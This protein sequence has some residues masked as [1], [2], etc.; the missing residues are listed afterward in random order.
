LAGLIA[1]ANGSCAKAEDL[2][3]SATSGN[4]PSHNQRL[5]DANKLLHIE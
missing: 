4:T 1:E 2:K 3:R 5:V